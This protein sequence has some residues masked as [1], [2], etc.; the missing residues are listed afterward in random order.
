MFTLNKGFY[1]IVTVHAHACNRDLPVSIVVAEISS[2][3]SPNKG[4]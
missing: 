2:E 3:Y 4:K 1:V